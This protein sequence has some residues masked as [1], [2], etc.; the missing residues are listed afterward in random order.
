MTS[1]TQRTLAELRKRGYLAGVV[2]KWNQYARVRQ[3]LWGWVDIVAL[4]PGTEE[5]LFIQTTS[6]SNAAARVDKILKWP[7]TPALIALGTKRSVE[8]WSWRKVVSSSKKGKRDGQERRKVWEVK[9]DR[10][11]SSSSLETAASPG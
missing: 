1:P 7:G 4:H 6:T 2:E 5:L 8:V 11:M 3:D 9:I 10:V